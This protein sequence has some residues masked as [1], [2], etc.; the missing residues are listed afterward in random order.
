MTLFFVIGLVFGSFFNVIGLRLPKN[1]SFFCGRSCCFSCE[2]T[3][4]WYELIPLISFLIQ[5]GRC[6]R[7]Y[8]KISY[9][10]PFSELMTGCLF[11]MSYVV[12][13]MEA[14]LFIAILFVSMSMI[15]FVSDLHYMLIPNK[16]L[17]FFLPLFIIVR[18]VYPLTPWWTTII[19][20]LIGFVLVAVIILASRGGMGAGDMKLL[21]ILGIVLG[22]EK[23]LLTFLLA[24]FGG[25]LIGIILL[26]FG[27]IKQRQP[28]P[29]APF[30]LL[31]SMI[32]YF[33]GDWIIP[34][35]LSFFG[36]IDLSFY[37]SIGK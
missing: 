5:G 37:S 25:A 23:V 26:G 8:E 1:K 35:Y 33:Y 11:L 20:A 19:G 13:G 30:I 10:Y 34:W 3:L 6:R 2:R 22:V 36:F 31:A 15:I 27:Q 32:A 9:I 7:C 12:I 18:L 4:L 28:I 24:C 29:F 21:A 14:E 17:L 16:I